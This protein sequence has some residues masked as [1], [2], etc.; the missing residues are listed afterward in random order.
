MQLRNSFHMPIAA[1]AL[2]LIGALGAMSAAANWF[3][4]RS[5]HEIHRVNARSRNKSSRCG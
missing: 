2:I 3:C 5:L 1:K 4:L